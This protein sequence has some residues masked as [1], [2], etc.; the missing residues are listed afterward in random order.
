ML[1]LALIVILPNLKWR[2][3]RIATA[4]IAA[5][6]SADVVKLLVGR[7]RPALRHGH[8]SATDAF[9]DCYRSCMTVR[10]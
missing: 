8:D 3:P 4:A 10:V 6:L 9:G 2:V 5:G 7:Q 1:L